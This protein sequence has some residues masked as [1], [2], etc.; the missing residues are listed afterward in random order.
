MLS[1]N[2]AIY[3]TTPI[4]VFAFSVCF[5]GETIRMYKVVALIVCFSGVVLVSLFTKP[6]HLDDGNDQKSTV[7]GYL[8]VLLSS[9]F[10]AMYE[11]FYHW[12]FNLRAEDEKE[13]QELVEAEEMLVFPEVVTDAR[14][15]RTDQ[16]LN[17]L[18]LMTVI[19]LINATVLLPGTWLV[20]FVGLEPTLVYPTL[21]VLSKIVALGTLELFYNLFLFAG[22]AKAGPVFMAVGQVLVVPTGYLVEIIEN[23]GVPV[24]HTLYNYAG[25]ALIL[26][27]FI[28]LQRGKHQ[29]M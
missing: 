13:E 4:F 8:L 19:G 11:V 1:A 18:R 15:E 9:V 21:P 24:H 12:S 16:L 23:G 26:V 2:N 22:I 14:A 29:E 10:F 3:Q 17:S 6:E 27:G 5:L 25:I 20:S 7:T 28:I